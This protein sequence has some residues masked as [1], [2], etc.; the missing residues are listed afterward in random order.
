MVRQGVTNPM[1][2]RRFPDKQVKSD[3]WPAGGV[4]R[5]NHRMGL[6]VASGR[7]AGLS[8]IWRS[9]VRGRSRPRANEW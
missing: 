3:K 6:G 1:L 2:G 8:A 7:V 4:G 9:C 5:W